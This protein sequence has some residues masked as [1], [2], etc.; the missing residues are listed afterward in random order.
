MTGA[1][2]FFI[3]AVWGIGRKVSG[4]ALLVAVAVLFK[5]FDA[6]L[7]SLPVRHGAVANPAFAFILEGAA[8]LALAVL[9]GDGGGR[10]TARRAVW[11]ASAALLAALAFPLVKFATG[12]PACV[13][14]GTGFPLAYAYA[15]L[16]VLI[17][18]ATVPLGLRTG[19]RLSA[20][21]FRFGAPS[22]ALIMG[23]AFMVFFRWL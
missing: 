12:I 1:A 14:P 8:F 23:L 6:V 9:I 17:S 11:G 15:P 16:A 2:L 5:M 21:E 7:L 4:V 20:F 3:A 19:E 13:V 10:R 18:A 22:L